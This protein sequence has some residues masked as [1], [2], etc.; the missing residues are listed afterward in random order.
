MRPR[1]LRK[2]AFRD[3]SGN[4]NNNDTFN[5]YRV[6]IFA[7]QLS[8]LQKRSPFNV[9]CLFDFKRGSRTGPGYGICWSPGMLIRWCIVK[10]ISVVHM[11]SYLIGTCYSVPSGWWWE[12]LEHPSLERDLSSEL[13]LQCLN[14]R[15]HLTRSAQSSPVQSNFKKRDFGKGGKVKKRLDGCR[16]Y[17]G[18]NQICSSQH[19]KGYKKGAHFPFSLNPLL[20]T[21][22]SQCRITQVGAAVIASSCSD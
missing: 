15:Q 10:L 5:C 1:M 17:V 13:Q 11:T 2:E 21:T 4:N 12:V 16:P 22:L 7:L 19:H 18:A 20:P 8:L 3:K 9:L 14:Y 6:S